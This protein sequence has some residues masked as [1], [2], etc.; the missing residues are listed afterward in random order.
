M[1]SADATATVNTVLATLGGRYGFSDLESGPFVDA[2]ADGGWVDYQSRRN[3][4]AGLGTA[5]GTTNG[6]VYSGRFGL[7]DVFRLAPLTVTLQAGVRASG[8]SLGAFKESGSDLAL[9]VHGINKTS[10]SL[11]IDLDVS[12]DRLELGAW[13]IAP[14][15]TLG[16]ERVL[17]NPQAD[18]LGTLYGFAVSQKSAYDSHDLMKAGLGL[19]ATRGAFSVKARGNGILGDGDSAGISGQL[20]LAYSF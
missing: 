7:G 14:A 13:T 3:L 18:S 6:A 8:V 5:T 20:S 11:L 19:T 10:S 2:R 17:G 16:Y 4:G 12:L 1:G 9:N 15:V